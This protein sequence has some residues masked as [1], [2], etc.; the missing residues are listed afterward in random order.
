MALRLL[1]LSGKPYLPRD[2]LETKKADI[3][4]LKAELVEEIAK[5]LKEKGIDWSADPSGAPSVP[6]A[7]DGAVPLALEISSAFVEE[8]SKEKDDPV[9][10]NKLLVTAK[11]TNMGEKPLFRMKGLSRSDFVLYKDQELLFGKV[12]PGQ[13]VERTVKV[14]LPYYPYARNDI[15]T[16][17]ASSTGDLP[18]GDSAPA[19]KPAD[20][21][22]ISKSI[23]IEL[24]DSGR[25]AFAYSA[26]LLDASSQKPLSALAE[27]MKAMLKVKV[28]NTGTAPAHKG[29][30][31]LRNE[32]GRQV[33]LE[34][35]RIEFSNLMPHG[36]TEVEF[37]FEVRSGEHVDHYD[38]EIVAADSYSSVT[39]ARKLSIPR[40][41]S[42]PTKD[43]AGPFPN[44]VEYSPP[45]ITASLVD[46]ETAKSVVLT[47]KDSLK[48]EAVIQTAGADRFKAWVFNSV[49]GNHE[50]ARDKILFAESEGRDPLK[51]AANV[52]LKKGINLFTVVSNGKNGLESQQSLVVRRE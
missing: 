36:E 11:L 27:G 26:R 49:V 28:K 15:F 46:P 6:E 34:K 18:A 38:F 39:L 25:P 13:S 16:V 29:I 48:L 40:E 8:P 14:R 23:Q 44:D 7:K 33:F 47:G 21:V 35:G 31:I 50:V 3:Q 4:R 10:V 43:S 5:H 32:T 1:K 52:P 51:I 45:F 30:A 2:V 19:D 24:E 9:P 17:E 22:L 20:K 42:A 41:G 12:E 37:L